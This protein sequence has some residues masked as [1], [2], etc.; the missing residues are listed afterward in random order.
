MLKNKGGQTFKLLRIGFVSYT[1]FSHMFVVVSIV[2]PPIAHFY[3]AKY[4]EN[5]VTQDFCTVLSMPISDVVFTQDLIISNTKISN[6][7]M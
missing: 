4:K 3:L 1:V 5:M 2:S 7:F 6:N